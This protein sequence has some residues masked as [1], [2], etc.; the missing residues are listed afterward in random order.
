MKAREG[1]V[2]K[3][4]WKKWCQAAGIDYSHG[5][6]LLSEPLQ[7]Q[8]LLKPCSHYC[9][10]FMHGLASKGALAYVVCWVLQALSKGGLP[11]IWSTLHDY[12]QLWKPP[13]A[14]G[15]FKA[16]KLFEAKNLEGLR[17]NKYFKCAA[18]EM[19]SLHR[20]LEYYIRT[21]CLAHGLLEAHCTCLLDWCAVLDYCVSIPL[22]QPAKPQV[23]LQLVEKA[24]AS[25]VAIGHAKDMRPKM[26]WCL[27]F[28]AEL[29]QFGMLPA[30]WVLERKHKAIRRH[31]GAT[32]N[33]GHYGETVTR[34][35]LCEEIM[36]HGD[37]KH[38]LQLEKC[39]LVNPVVVPK[40]LKESLLQYKLCLGFGDCFKSQSCK[41]KNG[42]KAFVGDFILFGKAAHGF[43]FQGGKI[44]CLLAPN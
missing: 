10:D 44:K 12:L 15:T 26:H 29:Q 23:L 30:C 37:E 35:M 3:G 4:E 39:C 19:L 18:S 32:F 16:Y 27:H 9:H 14:L 1:H 5:A 38:G 25:I 11:D 43:K 33:M 42:M 20:P 24:L 8:G 2:S 21:C 7:A 28:A 36:A 13:K 41:L 40:K 6:L 34:E 31:G 17:T 22:L